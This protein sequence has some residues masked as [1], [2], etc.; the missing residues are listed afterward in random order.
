ME[1]WD[2]VRALLALGATMA[3]IVLA[4]YG[5]RRFNWLPNMAGGPGKRLALVET[6]PLDPRRRLILV[7]CD[8][9]DHL[10]LLSPHGDRAIAAFGQ[11]RSSESA[12]QVGETP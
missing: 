2:W 9:R 10:L 3:L 4:G 7:R 11:E 1:A 5:A 6:L 8:G 12:N